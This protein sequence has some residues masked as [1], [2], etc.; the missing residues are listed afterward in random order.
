MEFISVTG[1][2]AAVQHAECCICFDD[3]CASP[4]AVIIT[5]ERRRA[6]SHYFHYE[7]IKDMCPFVTRGYGMEMEVEEQSNAE[8]K[9]P[10]CRAKGA[11]IVKMPDPVKDPRSWFYLVD[12]EHEGFLTKDN[13]RNIL[14]ATCDLH[15]GHLGKI[16]DRNW[17]T[18]DRDNSGGVTPSELPALLQF[19]KNNVPGRNKRSKPPHIV[20]DRDAWFRYWDE[21]NSGALDKDEVA[22]AVIKTFNAGTSNVPV[23]QSVLDNSWCLFDHTGSG[24]VSRREFLASD[25]LADTLLAFLQSD[26]RFAQVASP[27]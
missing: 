21:D 13:V 26:A 7:C 18:W 17:H 23:I 2:G 12:V 3:L 4:L 16:I 25:G 10:M 19:V 27:L 9:C 5:A 1:M 15:E 20:T 11:R 14:K 8:L 24:T 22:R 6:C